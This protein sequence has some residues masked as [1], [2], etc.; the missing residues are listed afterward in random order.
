MLRLLAVKH[1]AP[2]NLRTPLRFMVHAHMLTHCAGM[3]H[4]A[5]GFPSTQR[6]CECIDIAPRVNVDD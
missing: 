6:W 1:H 3:D 2:R 5:A 4:G